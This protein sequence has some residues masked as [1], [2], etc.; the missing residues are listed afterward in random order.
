MTILSRLREKRTGSLAT[1]IPA[2]SATQPKGDA[3]TVATV[4]TVAVASPTS[5]KTAPPAKVGPGDTATASRWWLIYYP[6]R[7]PVE[8]A[9]CPEATHDEILDWNPNAVS[10]IPFIPTIRHPP[11][12]MTGSE[13][14]AIRAWLV[15]IGETNPVAIT[16]VI[17]QCQ[18][19]ADA[20]GYFAGRAAAELNI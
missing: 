7:D 11:A 19:D 8:V 15:L 17:E 12:L 16:E 9:F 1:A 5:E 14:A 3:A 10:A 13:E 4:A 6:D 18:R 20:R 2:I